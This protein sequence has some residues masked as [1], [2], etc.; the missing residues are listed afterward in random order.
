[1]LIP[2]LPPPEFPTPDGPVPKDLLSSPS[3]APSPAP[4]SPVLL[5]DILRTLT[6]RLTTPLWTPTTAEDPRTAAKLREILDELDLTAR[7]PIADIETTIAL[8]TASLGITFESPA[9]TLL[10]DIQLGLPHLHTHP[11]TDPT[12]TM[13]IDP[14]HPHAHPPADVIATMSIGPL[15]FGGARSVLIRGI[16][17][18]RAGD[19]G[20]ATACGCDTPIFRIATGSSKV[21][22]GTSRAARSLD[23]THF[24]R[25]AAG[26]LGTVRIPHLDHEDRLRTSAP[27]VHD[28]TTESRALTADIATKPATA[29][30]APGIR[31]L[32]GNLMPGPGDVVIGGFPLP[33]GP[34]D[35]LGLRKAPLAAVRRLLPYVRCIAATTDTGRLKNSLA[36]ELRVYTGHRVDVVTGSL[37]LD[38]CDLELPGALPLRFTRSYSSTWSA[39]PSALG[40]GWSHGFDEAV[41]LEPRHLV[42]LTEHGR[43]LELPRPG[44]GEPGVFV[45]MHRLTVRRLADKRWQLTDAQGITRDFAPIAGDPRPGRARLLSRR[46]RA[47]HTIHLHHD[48]LARPVII[49]ADDD[50]ELRLHY[51]PAGHLTRLDLP[52]PDADGFLAHVRYVHDG[53]DLS[54]IHDALGQVTYYRHHQHRI[55]EEQLPGGPRF[56]FEYDGPGS[57]AACIRTR[58]DGGILDHRL[59]YDR[60]S[61]STIVINACRETTIYHADPRGLVR[62]ICD[63]RGAVTRREYDEHLR[64]VATTDALGHT[65]RRE[66]DARGNC[67]RHEAPDGAVTLTTYHPEFALPVARTDPAGGLWRWSYDEHGRVT[68]RTDPLGRST[69]HHHDLSAGTGHTETILHPDA[70]SERRIHDR[71]GRLVHHV[72]SDGTTH[73][74]HHD[75]R[76]RLRHSVDDRGRDE[77]R[78]YDLL[79]RLTRHVRPD[80][81]LRLYTHDPRGRIVRACDGRS[82]LRCSYAGPGWLISCGDAS[83]P[84]INLERDLEGRILRVAGASGTLLRVE[85]D[86]AGRVRIAVDAL[87]VERRFTRDLLGRVLI[88]RRPGGRLTRYTRDPAGRITAV[89]HGDGERDSFTYRPDGAMLSAEREHADGLVTVVRRQLDPLA[90]LVRE[91]QDEHAVALEYDLRDRLIRVRSSLGADLRF[92][93]DDRG[94][95]RIELPH[96]PWSM[97]FERDRDGR[98]QARHLPGE[99][100]CWWTTDRLGR[101]AEHGVVASRPPQLHHHRR[102]TWAGPRLGRIDD[103]ARRRTNRP[104]PAATVTATRSDAEGRRVASYLSDGTAWDLRWSDAGELL[105]AESRD[106]LIE[107]RHDALGRRV[108]RVRDGA[109]TRWFWHGDVPLHRWDRHRVAQAETWVFEPGRFAPLARLTATDRH[110]IV[111]DHLGTPLAAFDERGQIAWAAEFDATGRLQPVR[112]DP[113]LCP[114]RFPGQLT[115]PTTGLAHH[116]FRDHDPATDRYLAP[117]PLG[118][119]GGPDL[120]AHVADPRLSTDAYGLSTGLA[121][122]VHRRLAAELAHDF[123]AHDLPPAIAGLLRRD[124][125]APADPCLD[126]L[127]AIFEAP[128]PDD[129]E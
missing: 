69:E 15:M 39:R 41:W 48:H 56:H 65:E 89:E 108:A 97:S 45:P 118:L 27:R 1:M 112:G 24:C 127:R 14:S 42:Y 94:L 46:D 19:L 23:L 68:H 116:R 9:A 85:R 26:P 83:D 115:D 6:R 18:A 110:A 21:F 87:G 121:H 25:P 109:E 53:D 82:D 8:G 104:G 54:E 70:R 114:F 98:E 60:A 120:H 73:V 3:V 34:S 74:H 31:P 93:H 99:I 81:E 20:L 4:T 66:Y 95:A 16:P 57:D 47:G 128:R 13:S 28:T 80:G 10:K 100:H 12:A 75:R 77:T 76:G 122:G 55:I 126:L 36:R 78:E 32:H 117:N 30:T 79:G 113:D 40:R 38:A 125:P 35:R 129:R 72:L 43:E 51:D 44:I 58:G 67:T 7:L 103:L 71:A 88:T 61:C 49:K 52:D 33:P 107:Y 11:P 37:V 22:F 50:R 84:P 106:T 123:P 91:Q 102:Y 17:A 86:P 92:C 101:P 63:P 59:I 2:P 124:G 64:L 105:S 90:R 29:T 96:Q 5:L 111:G 119:L 62:E